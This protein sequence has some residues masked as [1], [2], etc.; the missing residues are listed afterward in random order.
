MTRLIADL[1]AGGARAYMVAV[2]LLNGFA[3]LVGGI[4]LGL[5]ELYPTAIADFTA[6]LSPVQKL[7]LLTAWGAAV[8]YFMRQGKRA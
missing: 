4:V 5:H 8:H 3:L 2:Q 1:R 7:V 6:T